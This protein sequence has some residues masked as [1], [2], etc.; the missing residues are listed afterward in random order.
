MRELKPK[1]LRVLMV[2][3]VGED[4]S[5]IFSRFSQFFINKCSATIE[6]T[7]KK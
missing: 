4:S 2:L 3:R 7:G 1:H 6:F 5:H